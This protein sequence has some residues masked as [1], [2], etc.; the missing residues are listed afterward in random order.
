MSFFMVFALISLSCTHPKA[1][2]LSS[3]AS[4]ESTL[5]AVGKLPPQLEGRLRKQT[6]VFMTSK[7]SLISEIHLSEGLYWGLPLCPLIFS[8]LYRCRASLV[9]LQTAIINNY[10]CGSVVLVKVVQRA[11]NFIQQISR[12]PANKMYWWIAINPME[13]Y[14]QTRLV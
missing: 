3:N 11:D 6:S 14:R 8:C 12:H 4:H 9:P 13:N 1:L 10:H 5:T 2:P 7:N